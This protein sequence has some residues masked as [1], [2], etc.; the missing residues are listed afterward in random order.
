MRLTIIYILLLSIAG[1]IL[2]LTED[3]EIKEQQREVAEY[4]AWKHKQDSTEKAEKAIFDN[5]IQPYLDNPFQD[6]VDLSG[7]GLKK[8]PENFLKRMFNVKYLDLSDNNLREVPENLF[9]NDSLEVLDLSNNNITYFDLEN[10][11]TYVHENLRKLILRNAGLTTYPDVNY[12]PN[13]EYLDI[14]HNSL[15]H[16]L[17]FKNSECLYLSYIDCSH[18]N[19]GRILGIENFPNLQVLIANNNALSG[20]PTFLYNEQLEYLDLS[21][22]NIKKFKFPV[23]TEILLALK[24]I[25]INDN[26]I[27]SIGKNVALSGLQHLEI[28]NNNLNLLF[29][30]KEHYPNLTYLDIRYNMNLYGSDDYQNIDTLLID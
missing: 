18:N 13:L 7:I 4:K 24:T 21:H 2:F 27:Q 3:Y 25:K 11:M 8:L 22:N 5:Y 26:K 23:Y 6:T 20:I 12:L 10:E 14:S 9:D 17:H 16:N 29:K 30:V 1:T 19:F 15:N 28:R